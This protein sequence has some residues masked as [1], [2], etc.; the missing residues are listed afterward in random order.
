MCGIVAFYSRRDAVSAA[1]MN[2]AEKLS[3]MMSDTLRGSV[4]ASIPFFD[5]KKVIALLD[6][7]SSMDETAHIAIDPTLMMLMSACVLH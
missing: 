2:P 7:L 3:T 1:A 4:F 6:S 5:Q